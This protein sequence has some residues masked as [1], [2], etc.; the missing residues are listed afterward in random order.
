MKKLFVFLLVLLFYCA[1]SFSQ[2]NITTNLGYKAILK[3]WANYYKAG[4]GYGVSGGIEYYLLSSDIAASSELSYMKFT[5]L[6]GRPFGGPIPDID[7]LT[8]AGGIKY[9]YKSGG[10][11]NYPYFGAKLGLISSKVQDT[12][13]SFESSFMWAL[14][15]GIRLQI[16]QSGTAIDANTQFNKSSNNGKRI[17]FFGFNFGLAFAL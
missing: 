9:F 10:S 4:S 8:F 14:Q 2:I 16:P 13:T 3:E 5:G 1:P 17:A 15:V 6:Q 12:G 7:V 11:A